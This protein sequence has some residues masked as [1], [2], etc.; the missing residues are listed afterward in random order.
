MSSIC[1]DSNIGLSVEGEVGGVRVDCVFLFGGLIK[2]ESEGE[3]GLFVLILSD[4]VVVCMLDC[5]RVKCLG[6]R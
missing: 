3:G 6:D 5:V 4:C 2:G 1:F